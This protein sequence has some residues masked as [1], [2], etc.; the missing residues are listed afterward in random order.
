M[1]RALT[2]AVQAR[3]IFIAGSRDDY[4]RRDQFAHQLSD[5]DELISN[6][7]STPYQSGAD[8]VPSAATD[9]FGAD[10]AIVL[11][12]LRAVGI[13]QVLV[14]NLG[15]EEIGVPVVRVIVPSFEGYMFDHYTP[16]S[17]ARAWC[18]RPVTRQ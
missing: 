14:V 17:R 16:G 7:L 18:D 5:S 13:E 3:A 9:C 10:I 11:A 6:V 8:A 2:E 1:A 15:H 12:R 4:F